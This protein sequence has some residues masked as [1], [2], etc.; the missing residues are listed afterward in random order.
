MSGIGGVMYQNRSG[1]VAASVLKMSQA[2]RRPNVR[3][4]EGWLSEGFGLFWQRNDGEREEIF[5]TD[6]SDGLIWVRRGTVAGGNGAIRQA[7]AKRGASFC[8]ELCGSFALALFDVRR[9][10]L[11]LA[12]GGEGSPPL[13]LCTEN[14]RVLFASEIKGILAAGDGSFSVE[15][16][17]LLHYLGAPVS[18]EIPFYREISSLPLAHTA[19]FNR[20]GQSLFSNGV[21]SEARRLNGQKI[22]VPNVRNLT[23]EGLRE[24]LYEALAVFDCPFFDHT[25]PFLSDLIRRNLDKKE[26]AVED[27]MLWVSPSYAKSRA[28]ALGAYYGLWIAPIFPKSPNLKKRDWKPMEKW[29]RELLS[30]CDAQTMHYLF[31]RDYAE[32][33]SSE[34]DEKRRI[35]MMGMMIQAEML[36]R[37]V[38]FL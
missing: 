35:R 3:Q 5:A 38:A 14:F 15:R 16:S 2:M 17:R 18:E 4:R 26:L 30:E 8:E 29:L 34:P 36:S 13:Y 32:R 27:D 11:M 25:F 9:R 20:L 12:R 19:V 22:G 24:S 28:N 37:R 31:G 23:R 10:E 6:E 7:Y 21:R 1:E 33:I